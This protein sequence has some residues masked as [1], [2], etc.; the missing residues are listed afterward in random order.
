LDHPGRLAS[1]VEKSARSNWAA[2]FLTVAYGGAS[3]LS[4]VN[5]LRRLALKE[6]KKIGGSPRLHVV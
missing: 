3:S 2:Q 1:L 5:F 4:G 6:K